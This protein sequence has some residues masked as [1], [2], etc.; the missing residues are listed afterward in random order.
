MRLAVG[1]TIAVLALAGCG[2]VHATAPHAGEPTWHIAYDGYGHVGITGSGADYH[3]TLEP[4]RPDS[5]T[6]THSALV[7]SASTWG[8]VTVEA[9]VRTNVQLRKPHPNTWEVGWLLWHYLD[10]QHFYYI[11]LKPNGFELGKEDP[12]YPGHQHF[13][14][15][16][17]RPT[18]PVGRWYVVRVQQRGDVINVSVNGRHLVRYIDT[19]NP[20]RSGRIGLYT[21]D[22][23]VT[24]QAVKLT[25]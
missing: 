11:I 18:F 17:Q 5:A 4:A 8:D 2:G 3:I 7:L 13:L 16:A 25:P 6:S 21:E 24:Y 14:V 10:N 20:Y 12:G 1:A 15:T 22:A 9:R 19:H 23:S